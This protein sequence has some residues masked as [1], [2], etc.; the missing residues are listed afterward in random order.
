MTQDKSDHLGFIF[1]VMKCY[2]EEESITYESDKASN[3][4]NADVSYELYM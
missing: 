1:F 2:N 3:N 4:I